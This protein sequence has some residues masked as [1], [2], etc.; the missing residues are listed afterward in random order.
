MSKLIFIALG[1]A[2][3]ASS[4]DLDAE[5]AYLDSVAEEFNRAAQSL[6]SA[7]QESS[8]LVSEREKLEERSRDLRDNKIPEVES[9]IRQHNVAAIQKIA[10]KLASFESIELKRRESQANARSDNVQL[11]DPLSEEDRERIAEMLSPEHIITES[12]NHMKEWFTTHI[13]DAFDAAQTNASTTVA[14]LESQASTEVAGAP[15]CIRAD[16]AASMVLKSL[17]A[18]SRDGI[19]MYDY[20]QTGEIVHQYT[21]PTYTVPTKSSLGMVWWE[22]FVPEDWEKLLPDGWKS[23]DIGAFP[24]TITH[25]LGWNQGS[26]V[27]PP[28]AILH[29]NVLPGACWP[30]KGSSGEVTIRLANPVKVTAVT[31][32]HA[33][34]ILLSQ[35]GEDAYKSAPKRVNVYGMPLCQDGCDGLGYDRQQSTLIQ[36]LEFNFEAGGIQTFNVSADKDTCETDSAAT[37][38]APAPKVSLIS[39]VYSAIMLEIQDNYGNEDFTCIYRVRIHGE[40][41][42]IHH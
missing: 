28:E 27:A 24:N 39:G 40:A 19:G 17:V 21:S 26:S 2:A 25:T 11:Y 20:A 32:E 29:P 23:W 16:D 7:L 9:S 36:E 31:L 35:L 5:F 13:G 4:S 34:S 37:C 30:M 22:R 14:A 3:L 15:V 6:N 8:K 33:S 41:D 1:S 12:E 10:E 38:S 42:G 18:F